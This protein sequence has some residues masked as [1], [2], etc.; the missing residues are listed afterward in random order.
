MSNIRE[1]IITAIADSVREQAPQAIG[2]ALSGVG[3]DSDSP[4]IQSAMN[5]VA[6]FVRDHGPAGVD[7]LTDKLIS[8]MSGGRDAQRAIHELQAD[9]HTLSDLVD[10]LQS[11]EAQ[12]QA[13]ADKLL[14]S[15][16]TMLTDVSGLL[17]DAVIR[18][19][20]T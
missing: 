18:S 5:I 9:G 13:Q 7:L 2:D 8:A 3:D 6:D 12:E 17:T 19:L 15:I 11:A 1:Q 10:A 14:S 20:T 16:G 4:L